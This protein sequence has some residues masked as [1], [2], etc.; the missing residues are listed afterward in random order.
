MLDKLA[1]VLRHQSQRLDYASE[2][3]CESICSSCIF[4]TLRER[5]LKQRNLLHTPR[6][7]SPFFPQSLRNLLTE[8][9]S[10]LATVLREKSTLVGI[11]LEICSKFPPHK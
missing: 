10:L 6:A 3:V 2:R 11:V 1:A 5:Q 9:V 7:P 8:P 4:V